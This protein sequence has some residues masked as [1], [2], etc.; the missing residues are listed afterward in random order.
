MK[1]VN[2]LLNEPQTLGF[3]EPYKVFAEKLAF[4]ALES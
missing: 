2:R 3:K 1:K 4:F